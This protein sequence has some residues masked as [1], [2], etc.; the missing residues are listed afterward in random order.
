MRLKRSLFA[1][2]LLF[3]GASVPSAFAGT[4]DD[5]RQRDALICGVSQGVPGFSSAEAGGVWS[6]FDVDFCHA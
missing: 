3:G 6:G 1:L 5:I 4:L 2:A